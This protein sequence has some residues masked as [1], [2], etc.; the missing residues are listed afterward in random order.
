MARHLLATAP[1]HWQAAMSTSQQSTTTQFGLD[2]ALTSSYEMKPTGNI[3]NHQRVQN[4]QGYLDD[5]IAQLQ[6]EALSPS[7]VNNC[8]NTFERF[9]E[10]TV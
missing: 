4:H 3:P 8:A 7:R 2:P 5:Y 6:D 10:Q 1:H 9:I